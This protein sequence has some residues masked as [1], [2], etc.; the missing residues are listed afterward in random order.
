MVIRIFNPCLQAS[1][2]DA[3]IN[4]VMLTFSYDQ[5][6]S[7]LSLA[8]GSW[9]VGAY[10]SVILGRSSPV[11]LLFISSVRIGN[12]KRAQ[13]QASAPVGKV[14]RALSFYV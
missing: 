2:P 12:C 9:R 3:A 5:V 8:R 13:L 14:I 6:P 4:T 11:H 1:C 7:I 10:Q